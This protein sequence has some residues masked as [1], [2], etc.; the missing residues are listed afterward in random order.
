MKKSELLFKCKHIAN[1]NRS[2]IFSC[3]EII[4]LIIMLNTQAFISVI[5]VHSILLPKQV[6]LIYNTIL[7][8]KSFTKTIGCSCQVKDACMFT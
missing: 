5:N 8:F 3:F 4:S 2:G 7:N 1:E 6:S